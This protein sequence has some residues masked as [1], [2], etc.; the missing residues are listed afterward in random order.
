MPLLPTEKAA[1]FFDTFRKKTAPI[2]WH[3]LSTR[4]DGFSPVKQTSV[5]S[6][7]NI[8]RHDFA[9][10]GN[11]AQKVKKNRSDLLKFPVNGV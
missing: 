9:M 11:V 2:Q 1:H 6:Q 5:P 7:I 10:T 3:Q 4:R 8:A